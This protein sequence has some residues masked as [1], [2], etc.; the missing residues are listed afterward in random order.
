M[1]PVKNVLAAGV[2][3]SLAAIAGLYAVYSLKIKKSRPLKTNKEENNRVVS[4]Q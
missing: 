4:I 2:L 1:I 3:V